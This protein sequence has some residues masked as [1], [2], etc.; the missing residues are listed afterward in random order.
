[1]KVKH[2]LTPI[3]SVWQMQLWLTLALIQEDSYDGWVANTLASIE[4]HTQP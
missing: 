2:R 1:M 3:K 4:M